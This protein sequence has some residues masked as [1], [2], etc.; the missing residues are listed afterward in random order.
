MNASTTPLIAIAQANIV[1]LFR[2]ANQFR[3]TA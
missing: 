2:V 3:T 1:R